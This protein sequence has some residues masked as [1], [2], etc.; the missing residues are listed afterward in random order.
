MTE[1]LL[2]AQL[3]LSHGDENHHS[4]FVVPSTGLVPQKDG[5]NVVGSK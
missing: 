4:A 1:R 3:S 5:R 2:N